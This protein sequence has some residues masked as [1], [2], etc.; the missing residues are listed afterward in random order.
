MEPDSVNHA[1]G[2]FKWDVVFKPHI[3]MWGCRVLSYLTAFDV[4]P[5][6]TAVAFILTQKY[7]DVMGLC[8]VIHQKKVPLGTPDT[9]AP[10]FPIGVPLA[11]TG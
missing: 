1:Y 2:I 3:E 11:Q 10:V 4:V 8:W 9:V 5:G 6:S 7:C